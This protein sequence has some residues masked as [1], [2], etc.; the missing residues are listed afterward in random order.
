MIEDGNDN[1]WTCGDCTDIEKSKL[2]YEES[3]N[4]ETNGYENNEI[5]VQVCK[6]IF[7]SIVSVIL[8]KFTQKIIATQT[9]R[10]LVLSNNSKLN[11]ENYHPG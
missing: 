5:D 2:I 11:K 7:E 1:K 3:Y 8:K 4:F 9:S 6:I 10:T